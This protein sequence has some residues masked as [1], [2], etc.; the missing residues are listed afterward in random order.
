MNQAVALNL[1]TKNVPHLSV[2]QGNIRQDQ[3]YLVRKGFVAFNSVSFGEV[4]NISKHGMAIQYL[5]RRND[6]HNQ[7]T[8][9]NLINSHEGF[10]LSE[11]PCRMAYVKD[12]ST[13]GKIGV[14]RRI[15]IEFI[16]LTNGQQETISALMES[17]TV[18]EET[19][20]H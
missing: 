1:D 17:F 2:A 8:E 14:V 18:G 16:D 5:S 7:M 11:I 4:L 20:Q 15:G 10:L 3:R 12:S 9:I 6:E 13:A 19:R